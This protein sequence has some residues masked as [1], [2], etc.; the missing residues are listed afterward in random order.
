MEVYWWI[1]CVCRRLGVIV[2]VLLSLIF[3]CNIR[4]LR[5]ILLWRV[6][7]WCDVK[8]DH[9]VIISP[10]SFLWY[11]AFLLATWPQALRYVSV[12][13]GWYT[14]MDRSPS[15]LCANWAI[16]LFTILPCISA[17]FTRQLWEN[18]CSSSML[19]LFS[20]V[21]EDD[22]YCKSIWYGSSCFTYWPCD[23]CSIHQSGSMLYISLWS[24]TRIK[25]NTTT[26]FNY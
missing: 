12:T 8:Y 13:L 22:V 1:L 6:I 4:L 14:Q 21:G 11:W 3:Y 24:K 18:P 15:A 23:Q 25:H 16:I 19:K 2:S 9:V 5:K 7:G 20:C 10:A 26:S 17:S